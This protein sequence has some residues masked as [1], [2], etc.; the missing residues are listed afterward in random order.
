ML[1]T[2]RA[3]RQRLAARP[4]CVPQHNAYRHTTMPLSQL[5]GARWCGHPRGGARVTVRPTLQQGV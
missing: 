5:D 1:D 4:F 2:L 3:Y